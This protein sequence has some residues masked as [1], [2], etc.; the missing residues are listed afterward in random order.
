MKKKTLGTIALCLGLMAMPNVKAAS[1][2]CGLTHQA[3]IG[4]T[5]YDTLTSALDEVANKGTI[6]L[7][8]NVTSDSAI[9]IT[10]EVTIDLG[11]KTI[12]FPSNAS[13][14]FGIDVKGTTT[15]KNGSVNYEANQENPTAILV[16]NNAS[17]DLENVKVKALKGTGINLYE[18]NGTLNVDAQS[19]VSAYDNAAIIAWGS[20]TE[21]NTYTLNL[22]GT[23]E[24]L[25]TESAFAGINGAY[26]G[27]NLT[28]NINIKEGAKATS[29]NGAGILQMSKGTV[30]VEGSVIGGCSSIAMTR[31]DLKVMPGAY[32]E[33]T[34]EGD[35]DE[36]VGSNNFKVY[37]NGAAIYLEPTSEN[38]SVNVTGGIV[39]S[40]HGAALS[41]PANNGNNS[42]LSLN[43]ED[44]TFEGIAAKGD[45]DVYGIAES[46]EGF[47]KGG[48]FA[49]SVDA[50]YLV[51]GKEQSV[52]GKIGTLYNISKETTENGEFTVNENAVE[53]EVVEITIKANTGYKVATIKVMKGTDEIPV[54]GNS[55][56]MP[57]GDVKVSVTF[58]KEEVKPNP[59][60]DDKE[61]SGEDEKKPV[62][63]TPV[64]N[65]NTFD[66]I[67]GYFLLGATSVGSLGYVVKKYLK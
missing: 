26:A 3:M 35:T 20:T 15:L 45:I 25:G 27:S 7:T 12:N 66:G 22:Y 23:A 41:A 49:N 11:N 52:S 39:K 50:K 16:R 19:I 65:P 21:A 46:N 34:K 10:K 33:S 2:D 67:L 28:F 29:V 60:N 14:R 61:E 38:M 8:D 42:K 6:L 54:N 24:N 31:G 63:D 47:I 1:V 37:S 30:T 43:I 64:K 5:C 58:V 18:S 4:E 57:A 17:L 40:S 36:F 51:A 32:V 53:G 62:D 13:T 9:T 48:N 56:V 59:D 55:F 44:G